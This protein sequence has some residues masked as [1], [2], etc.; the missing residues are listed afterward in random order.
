MQIAWCGQSYE[1]VLWLLTATHFIHVSWFAHISFVFPLSTHTDTEFTHWI[2]AQLVIIIRYA[3]N[4]RR[5]RC[6]LYSCIFLTPATHRQ[7]RRWLPS[8]DDNIL[9]IKYMMTFWPAGVV[10]MRSGVSN[11][12]GKY[13]DFA[14]VGAAPPVI[15]LCACVWVCVSVYRTD[16]IHPVSNVS[17]RILRSVQNV[18]MFNTI[19]IV[20]A[21]AVA[22]RTRCMCMYAVVSTIDAFCVLAASA[23]ITHGHGHGLLHFYHKPWLIHPI[24]VTPMMTIWL[25]CKSASMLSTLVCYFGLARLWAAQPMSI[26]RTTTQPN[27]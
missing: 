9:C 5:F 22:V 24:R 26:V 17:E 4:T 27:R 21:A 6:T 10:C 2:I 16:N 11:F 18:S 1:Y 25:G 20:R 19:C 23:R 14:R 3:Q 12:C 8:S 15:V 7:H 13:D